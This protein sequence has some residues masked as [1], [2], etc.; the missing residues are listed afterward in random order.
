M[1]NAAAKEG[2][3]YDPVKDEWGDM[4]EGMVDGWRG[5]VA[6]MDE[7]V[8]YVV[9][10]WKGV[11]RRYEE[12]RDC[13]VDVLVEE[14][15]RGAHQMAAGG[16]R[17]CVVCGGGGESQGIVVVDVAATPVRIWVVEPPAGFK[18]VAVHILPRM[19]MSDFQPLLL[20]S[21]PI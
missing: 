4:A 14:R 11:L 6:A 21:T 17:I 1:V 13:W 16:G 5:P 8:V 7:E 12:E 10:E 9:D 3:V 2:A 19:S 18:A 15:L 20:P